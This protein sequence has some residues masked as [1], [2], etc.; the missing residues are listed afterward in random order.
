MTVLTV[1]TVLATWPPA[2]QNRYQASLVVMGV[3]SGA[4]FFLE[5]NVLKEGEIVAFSFSVLLCII[6]T[7]TCVMAPQESEESEEDAVPSR[8][9]RRLTHPHPHPHPH[10]RGGA[11]TAASNPAQPS[12]DT[13]RKPRVRPCVQP[14]GFQGRP[15]VAFVSSLALCGQRTPC[16]SRARPILVAATDLTEHRVLPS[17]CAQNIR[18]TP[19]GEGMD[20]D[21]AMFDVGAKDLGYDP[22]PQA[23]SGGYLVVAKDDDGSPARSPV[24][25]TSFVTE[26]DQDA[27]AQEVRDLQASRRAPCSFGPLGC[28]CCCGGRRVCWA[29][30]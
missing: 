28:C 24:K 16:V 8:S 20:Q 14:R 26:D 2:P 3:A 11:S 27:V 1:L 6:G 25:M 9:R 13:T 17:V 10:L 30:C 18:L 19:L 21:A 5:L 23:D 4:A 29:P 7:A 15:V 22:E 12:P